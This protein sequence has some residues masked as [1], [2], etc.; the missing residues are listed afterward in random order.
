MAS[1][2][3]ADIN[4][5]EQQLR[6][7]HQQAQEKDSQGIYHAYQVLGRKDERFHCMSDQFVDY[8]DELSA[9]LVRLQ[10]LQKKTQDIELLKHYCDQLCGKFV[11]LQTTLQKLR[12][13]ELTTYKKVEAWQEQLKKAAN[14]GH[15]SELYAK[16]EQQKVFE[17]RLTT[18]IEQQIRQLNKSQSIEQ[19]AQLQQNILDLKQRHGRC[20]R[21]TWQIEQL[22][23]QK[24]SRY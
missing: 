7:L 21:A 13:K 15:L 20:Q 23:S 8:A 22:I 19:S 6:L 16:L 5:L 14:S 3:L 1:W 9:D 24:Q 12:P 2:V 18:Q 10:Q 4:K 11:M 17:E